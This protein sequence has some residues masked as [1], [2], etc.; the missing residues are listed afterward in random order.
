M[1]KALVLR[2]GVG[3]HRM[4][5]GIVS[6]QIAAAGQYQV[7]HPWQRIARRGTFRCV[8]GCV[9]EVWFGYR[10]LLI[11]IV[12]V[13]NSTKWWQFPMFRT[14]KNHIGCDISPYIRIWIC[15]A[16]LLGGAYQLAR[17]NKLLLTMLYRTCIWI[18]YHDLHLFTYTYN[19][20]IIY[21]S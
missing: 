15:L 6:G 17:F 8:L 20:H 21:I 9:V 12:P 18:I 4:A 19:I 10:R 3:C 7:S 16:G 14:P 5:H 13:K 2:N 1:S 11:N